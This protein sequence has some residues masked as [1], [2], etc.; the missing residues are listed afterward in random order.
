MSITIFMFFM[1]SMIFLFLYIKQ[2][3]K[4]TQNYVT[5][6]LLLVYIN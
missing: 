5:T 3:Y 2:N 6:K 1:I 4:N